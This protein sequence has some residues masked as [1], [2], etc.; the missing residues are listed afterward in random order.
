VFTLTN[1]TFL[2]HGFKDP[3]RLAPI[4]ISWKGRLLSPPYPTFRE[5]A[6]KQQSFSE[7]GAAGNIRPQHFVYNG[8]EL[9][10]LNQI[11]GD[12]VSANYFRMLGVDAMQGRV[13][14]RRTVRNP[15]KVP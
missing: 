4:S 5:L 12:W 7:L 9:Q 6:A 15:A 13:F 2:K 3:D 14:T 8:T 1:A 11:E 10:E